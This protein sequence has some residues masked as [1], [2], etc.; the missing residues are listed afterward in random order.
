MQPLPV[1]GQPVRGF[2]RLSGTNFVTSVAHVRSD[3]WL[4]DGFQA[5]RS[6]WERLRGRVW[7]W[8]R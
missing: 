7:R 6:Y 8:S 4:L 3:V 2:T 5:P 1:S